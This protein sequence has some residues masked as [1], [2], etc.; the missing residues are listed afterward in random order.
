[1]EQNQVA[2]IKAPGLGLRQC[3]LTHILPLNFP[4]TGSSTHTVP[5]SP[6]ISLYP[7]NVKI[8][9]ETRCLSEGIEL[10]SKVASL[11]DHSGGQ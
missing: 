4:T 8:E 10:E 7:E 9:V 1:M 2:V 5:G 6:G 3:D 11:I